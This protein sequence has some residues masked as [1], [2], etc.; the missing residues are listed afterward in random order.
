MYIEHGTNTLMIEM[1]G[2][3]LWFSYQTV[4]AFQERG[5]ERRVSQNQWGN[6]TGKHIAAIEIGNKKDRIPREQFMNELNEIMDRK[7]MA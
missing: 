7:G 6:T 2:V 4:I 1:C 3:T 5:K